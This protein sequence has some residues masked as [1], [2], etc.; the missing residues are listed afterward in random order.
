MNK[1]TKLSLAQRLRYVIAL[2]RE[3]EGR[4]DFLRLFF[5]YGKYW[6]NCVKS[7]EG[8]WWI[9]EGDF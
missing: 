3:I 1:P 8:L 2:D 7:A 4:K 9:Q 5:K 6:Y